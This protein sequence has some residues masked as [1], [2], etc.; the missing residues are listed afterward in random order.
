MLFCL[1]S[2]EYTWGKREFFTLR[3]SR[4]HYATVEADFEESSLS[5]KGR[6]SGSFA[7][8]HANLRLVQRPESQKT[9]PKT[10]GG[11]EFF[12]EWRQEKKKKAF[13]SPN[14]RNFHFSFICS[15][16]EMFQGFKAPSSP[17][18][19]YCFCLRSPP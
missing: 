3:L 13:S 1:E 12:R 18:F 15:S 4:P 6:S 5:L 2:P 7:F 19:P 8:Y 9:F 14:K 10:L 11:F 17:P 16:G